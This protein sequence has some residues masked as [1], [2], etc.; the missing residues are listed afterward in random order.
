MFPWSGYDLLSS[1]FFF[2]QKKKSWIQ[3]SL[4]DIFY[5]WCFWVLFIP[6]V[7]NHFRVLHKISWLEGWNTPIL[8]RFMHKFVICTG[9][10]DCVYTQEFIQIHFDVSSFF[11]QL[12]SRYNYC[13]QI[14]HIHVCFLS[15]ISLQLA[16]LV[17][18]K[19]VVF[20]SDIKVW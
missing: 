20:W 19:F 17:L 7:I 9:H 4:T 2:L 8:T 16:H 18:S 12:R 13:S 15:C 5:T 14:L 1:F 3:K 11:L 6:S 10:T